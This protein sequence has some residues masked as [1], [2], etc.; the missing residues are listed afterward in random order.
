MRN[1]IVVFTLVL[2]SVS[3]FGFSQKHKKKPMP[4]A[5][6]APRVVARSLTVNV[7]S[8]EE[9]ICSSSQCPTRE[10]TVRLV[11]NSLNPAGEQR[12]FA[13]TVTGGRGISSGGAVTWVLK[14]ALPGVYT[15]S[16]KVSDQQSG[17]GQAQ[18]QIRVVDCGPCTQSSTPCPVVSV[19]CPEEIDK[20]AGLKFSAHVAGGP[21]LS[22]PLSYLWTV[23]SGTIV[24]GEKERDLEVAA[25]EDEEE[26]RGTVF[27]GGYD[28]NCSTIASCTSKIKTRSD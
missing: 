7:V 4:K 6:P 11:A 3:S 10:S 20:A 13:W 9:L 17:I 15:A 25:T 8:S 2:L 26:I 18:Q 22:A 16:V 27:V 23:S 12:S 19:V 28:S 21:L 24:R 5:K 1:A 14:G